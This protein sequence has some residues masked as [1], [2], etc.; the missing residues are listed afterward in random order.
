MQENIYTS[1]LK[2]INFDLAEKTLFIVDTISKV[3]QFLKDNFISPKTMVCVP[4][5]SNLIDGKPNLDSAHIIYEVFVKDKLQDLLFDR[6]VLVDFIDNKTD[7]LTFIQFLYKITNKKGELC[8]IF[9]NEII[10]N[11]DLNKLQINLY[12]AGYKS[13][14]AESLENFFFIKAMRI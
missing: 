11:F 13:C 6:I 1:F 3:N 2:K 7:M 8:A 9:N 14:K 4:Y 12:A 10:K 5:N